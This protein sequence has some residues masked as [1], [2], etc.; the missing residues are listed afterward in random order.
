MHVYAHERKSRRERFGDWRMRACMHSV[1]MCPVVLVYAL[2]VV[3]LA[4]G[5]L[6]TTLSRSRGVALVFALL[7]LVLVFVA[8]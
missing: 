8:S 1:R 7:V 4:D 3:I 5:R 6:C 2:C